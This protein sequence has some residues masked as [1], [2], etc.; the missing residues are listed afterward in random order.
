MR[1]NCDVLLL[2]NLMRA[3]RSNSSIAVRLVISR[4]KKKLW[5][6]ILTR[7]VEDEFLFLILFNDEAAEG[8][9]FANSH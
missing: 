6:A 2:M 7:L 4:A 8:V 3:P 5:N 1:D 9:H